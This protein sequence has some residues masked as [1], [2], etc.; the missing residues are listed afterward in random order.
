[1]TLANDNQGFEPIHEAHAIAQV[2]FIL[3]FTNPISESSFEDAKLK[4]NEFD[5]ELPGKNNITEQGIQIHLGN[6]GQALPLNVITTG[7]RRTKSLPDGAIES[8]LRI[9]RSSIT[10][11]TTRYTRWAT[12]WEQCTRYFIELLPY[13]LNDSN[14]LNSINLNYIDKFIWKDS[15]AT[16]NPE[17]LLRNNS[18][19]VSQH[20]FGVEDLWHSHT[21]AFIRF[22]NFTKRLVNVNVDCLDELHDD[23]PRRTIAIATSIADHFNQPDYEPLSTD[24]EPNKAIDDHMQSMHVL[25]KKIISELITENMCKRIALNP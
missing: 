9:E 3:Q 19:Y 1:M 8:D 21:G 25:G 17:L 13:Y 5:N 6:Q 11:I 7:V 10:F 24:I 23:K 16:C 14:F 2:A 22:D 4:S 18:R 15:P 20:I 12:I